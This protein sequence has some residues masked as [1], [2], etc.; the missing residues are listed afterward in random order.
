[1]PQ[2]TDRQETTLV[3]EE[4][5]YST[6]QP[7]WSHVVLKKRYRIPEQTYNRALHAIYSPDR[8]YLVL[9]ED[10]IQ[11]F[12]KFGRLYDFLEQKYPEFGMSTRV[13]VGMW[14]TSQRRVG[15]VYHPPIHEERDVSGY[16]P[17]MQQF[18]RRPDVRV[19]GHR[20]RTQ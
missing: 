11:N 13:Q 14:D 9:T 17:E 10:A 5:I 20:R 7:I 15:D 18:M 19:R 6:D 3:T 4:R 16:S 8:D 2:W 1:M 12:E